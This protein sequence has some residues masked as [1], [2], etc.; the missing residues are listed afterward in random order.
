MGCTRAMTRAIARA[1]A[2]FSQER[3]GLRRIGS[4]RSQSVSASFALVLVLLASGLIWQAFALPFG[5]LAL[6]TPPVKAASGPFFGAI[7]FSA[8]AFAA[9]VWTFSLVATVPLRVFLRQPAFEKLARDGWESL[10]TMAGWTGTIAVGI[11]LAGSLSLLI[12]LFPAA[13]A[14]GRGSIADLLVEAQLGGTLLALTAAAIIEAVRNSWLRLDGLPPLARWAAAIFLP[15]LIAVAALEARPFSAVSRWM[16]EVWMT[17]DVAGIPR[18]TAIDILAAQLPAVPA[19]V[20]FVVVA[21]HAP[22]AIALTRR[23]AKCPRGSDALNSTADQRLENEEV[24]RVD[25]A[26]PRHVAEGG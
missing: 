3:E 2:S 25:P 24:R 12:G 15:G 1:R 16:I 10:R 21:A 26:S 13:R 19:A 23:R 18:E 14:E 8:L 9:A 11:L 17:S 20:G 4:V 22:V 6:L 7:V 5:A